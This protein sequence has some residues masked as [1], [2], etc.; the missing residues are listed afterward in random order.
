MYWVRKDHLFSSAWVDLNT[1]AKQLGKHRDVVSK[2]GREPLGAAHAE[3]SAHSQLST[4]V[5]QLCECRFR[6]SSWTD[7]P[8][9]LLCMGKG[10]GEGCPPQS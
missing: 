8:V 9:I 5:Q 3:G 4:C 1:T 10:P 6:I 2:L 7:E